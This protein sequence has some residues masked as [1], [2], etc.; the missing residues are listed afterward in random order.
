MHLYTFKIVSCV[1]NSTVKP[2]VVYLDA[3]R[4]CN[5]LIDNP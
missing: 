2:P 1:T 3:V 5:S 4:T